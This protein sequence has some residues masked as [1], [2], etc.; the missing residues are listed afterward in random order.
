MAADLPPAS[1]LGGGPSADP[2]ATPAQPAP[3]PARYE[4]LDEIAHGGMGVVFVARDMVLNRDVAVKILQERPPPGPTVVRRFVE[5]AKI[6]GQLQHPGIPPVHDLGTLP[7]GRPFLAMKL[8]KGR[9]LDDLLKDRPGPS[10]DRGRFVAAFEQVCQAVAFAHERGVIHRDLKPANVMVGAFGEVQVMDWGLAKVLTGLAGAVTVAPDVEKTAPATVIESDRDGQTATRAGSVLGTPAYMPPEQAIGAVDQVDRRS[11]VFG[12]GAIL[13]QVLTGQPPYLGPD[14]EAI[15]QLAARARLA[16]A[17]G[18]LDGCGAEPGLVVLCKRCLS[19]EPADRPADA[20]EVAKA[21]AGLRAA[22]DERARRA[23]LDRVRAE[24]ERARAEAEAREQQRRRRAQLGL[25]AAVGLLLAGGG[26]FAW[27]QDRQDNAR[28][29][30]QR[31]RTARNADALAALLGAC[32]AALRADDADRAAAL[33]AEAERRLGDGGDDL[34][35]RVEAC[36]ADLALLRDLNAVDQF[37]WTWWEGKFPDG[38]VVGARL[39]V[40]FVRFG[41]VPGKFPDGQEVAAPSTAEAARRVAASAV[42]E[43][44]VTALDR[45]LWA[46]GSARARALLQA[47]DADGFR[48]AVRDA[49]LVGD[50][51]RVAELAGRA[52]A[53]A[54][55]A[56]FAAA[57]GEDW[58][59]PVGRRRELLAAALT[60]RPGDLSLLMTLGNTY[61]INQREGAEER[62]RWFQAAAA[63]QPSNPAVRNNLSLALRDMGRPDEAI[64][65]CDEAIRLDPKLAPAHNNRGVALRDKGRLDEAIAAFKQAIRVEPK[66]AAAYNSLGAALRD[67]GEPDEAIAAC[68]EAIR[69][70]PR[71]SYAHNNRGVALKDKGRLDEAVAAYKAAIRVDPKNALARSNLRE[72]ERWRELLPRL[73]DVAAGRAGAATP[74]EGCELAELCSEPFQRRYAAAVRLYQGAFAVDPKLAT[75][76]RNKAAYAAVLA[77]AGKDAELTTFGA[78]EWWYWTDLARQWLRTDLGL[79][80]VHGKDPKNL[81]RARNT[82]AWWKSTRDLAAVRDPAWL[83]AMP[84][85]DRQAWQTFWSDVDAVLAGLKPPQPVG[86]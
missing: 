57:L 18:R 5:E 55:P 13:C 60:R 84:P 61:P 37:R 72:V 54:Q 3:S 27:W 25:A 83:A 35:A 42:R 74:A 7:D 62:L 32:E 82:L 66:F 47:A 50:R 14:A 46:G 59:L 51:A 85:A 78:D 79:W 77:A 8:I 67:M 64:A 86:P 1:S 45:W 49:V 80:A 26:A 53:L 6:T 12:L 73:A 20:G 40:A 52:E 36:R 38:R 33:L 9:T 44:L 58:S 22:A 2:A 75:N 68:D 19:P 28:R 16:E 15:R 21:V 70:E 10:H 48:D 29:A 41:L 76:Y 39:R 71:L 81:S 65:A 63:A 11:D 56:G 17:L 43:R 34:R 23:E 30:E 31:Q 69:L 4:L 24:G